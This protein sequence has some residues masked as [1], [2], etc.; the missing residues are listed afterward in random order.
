MPHTKF[1]SIEKKMRF[2]WFDYELWQICKSF[3][4]SLRQIVQRF[5]FDL[6]FSKFLTF[7]RILSLSFQSNLK[8]CMAQKFCTRFPTFSKC[9]NFHSKFYFKTSTISSNFSNWKILFI[10]YRSFSAIWIWIFNC[11]LLFSEREMF[12]WLTPQKPANIH[13]LTRKKKSDGNLKFE[14]C[15]IVAWWF[16]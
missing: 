8:D 15:L 14:S 9:L 5:D 6:K 16:N 7:T 11:F 13:G 3:E 4:G 12:H 10:R 1:L 2:D